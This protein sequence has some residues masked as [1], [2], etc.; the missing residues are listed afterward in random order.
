MNKK[1]NPAAG[2]RVAAILLLCSLMV[3][4]LLGFAMP[5][6]AAGGDRTTLRTLRV[7]FYPYTGYNITSQN[8]SRSGYAY[9]LLQA[10]AQYE[11]VTFEYSCTDGDSQQAMQMLANGQIDLIP[12]LRRTDERE[13]QFAFSA[14]PIG[15]VAT[16][17]TIK[18]GNRTI[19]AG[20]YATYDGMVVGMSR[21]GNGRNESFIAYAKEHNFN[22]TTVYFDND[23]ELSAAL[24]AGTITAAVSNRL[25]QTTNEWVIDTFDEQNIYMA[26]RKDDTVT[27][28]LVNDA[29]GKINRNDPSW[30][31]TLFDKYYTGSHTSSKIYLTAA[32]ENYVTSHNAAGKVFTVL[33]N[34][35]RYPY[36]YMTQDGAPTGIMVDL[37]KKI[38]DRARLHYKFL[39]PA[40]RSEYKT[41]LE[42]READ[43]VIDLTDDF[44]RAEDYGYKLTD[45]YLSAEF[46]WVLQRSHSGGLNRVAVVSDLGTSVLEMP[47]LDENADIEHLD[48]F[49]ECLAALHS[50]DIDAYYTYTYQAEREIFDDKYNELRSMSSDERR[51]F[52]IGILNDYNVLLRSVLNKSVSSLTRADVID[53]TNRYINLGQQR[54]SLVRL[55]YQYPPI[56][57]L[58]CLCILTTVVCIALVIRSR[59]FRA[60]TEK[61]LRKAEE[62][63]A[64]KTEFLSNMSHDIRTPING[65]MG[66]LDIAENNFDDRD[67]VQDC[68]V[69][70]RGAASHLLSL[71]NDVLDM[72]KV[73]SGT[74]QMLDT[75]FD[76]RVLLNSCCSIIEGQLSDRKLTFTKQIGPFW[77]PNLR[78]SELHI[79]QVLINILS[80]AVKYTPDGGE[81]HFYA[82]ET[83][84]EEGL[85][86]LRIEI[87]DTGI[88]MTEEFLKHI[89]EPFTQ[90]QQSSRTTYK[91]TGLG[92][93]I[94]KKLVD[95]MHGS[96]DVE[97]TPGKGS[98]F[99]VRLSLPIADKPA[100]S[101]K[102]EE[103]AADLHG[104]HLLMAEDNELNREIAVTLLEEQGAE[105][106]AAENGREAVEIFQSSPRGTFDAV[107]MDV[108]MPEMNGLEATRAIRAFEGCP[109]DSGIPIIAM[110]AN[111]FADDVKACLE[112]GMN[113]HVG[114]PLDMQVLAAE[115]CREVRRYESLRESAT[116]EN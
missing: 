10:I 79:R 60:E 109:P 115:I 82:R 6:R 103:A 12:V 83:L 25:R 77:H 89:F 102:P 31:T 59:R 65:I 98:T 45:S 85:V 49:D 104:L 30:R 99:T 29:I 71:I 53:I 32:E 78:G 66:M 114:K 35:D 88:G 56:I 11:N 39:M 3:C 44:S 23:D 105:V 51:N 38:A 74:I 18:A 87:A 55:A 57:V 26:M 94:T 97:S 48:S 46:S 72:A 22:Y 68:L 42:N 24:R 86:H 5:V 21:N 75:D 81:I 33:V 41:M 93:A 110:T 58:T 91:G 100:V 63:S 80:N 54:F 116:L 84:F 67:R 101:D 92:M 8:G 50:G 52:C 36:S 76:L 90:E 9:E 61:A 7:G 40:D 95:Q 15:T 47:G 111:V 16:M 13:E 112:A 106:T 17:L 19:A 43:F 37:F 14:E 28:Q 4:L 108:M 62:A 70:M 34:P 27:Q 20:N 69:K 107:L 1:E 113:S 2:Q 73:E 64:A 96:L